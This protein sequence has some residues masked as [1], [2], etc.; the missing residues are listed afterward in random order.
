MH[1]NVEILLGR[2]AAEPRLLRRFRADPART[3]RKVRDEELELTEVECAALAGTDPEADHAFALSIDRRSRR[4][5][6]TNAAQANEK[7]R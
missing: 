1:K 5:A 2:P 3:L 7:D 4:A 6:T